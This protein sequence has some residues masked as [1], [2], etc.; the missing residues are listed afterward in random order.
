MAICDFPVFVDYR[1]SIKTQ[2]QS[3]IHGFKTKHCWRFLYHHG[4]LDDTGHADDFRVQSFGFVAVHPT[5]G[6]VVGRFTSAGHSP[7]D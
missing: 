4:E 1:I 5:V 6:L 7:S 3:Q 2:S